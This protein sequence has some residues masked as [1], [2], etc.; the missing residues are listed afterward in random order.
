MD[1]H[2]LNKKNMAESLGISTQAFDKWGVKPHKKIGRQTFFRVQDV[3]ENRIENEL[4]KNNNR[5]NPQGERIDVEFEK[6]KLTQQQRITQEIKN[7]ILEGKAIPVEAARDVL[8][9]IL[10]QVG[11]TLDSLAPNIKR[12]HP[13]IE[14]RIIDFIKSET[15]KHQNEASNLDNYLDDIIDDVITQAEAKV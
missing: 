4:K 15:I 10:A 2:L 9:R 11:A 13:E 12:R 8:A 5:V 3:V 14:Q 7:E 1:S 6:A